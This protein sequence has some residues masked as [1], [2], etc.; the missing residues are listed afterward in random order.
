MVV[1]VGATMKAIVTGT[2][3]IRENSSTMTAVPVVAPSPTD[4][5][6]APESFS[7][8][9]YVVRVRAVLPLWCAI[10]RDALALH[11]LKYS[12]LLVYHLAVQPFRL[13]SG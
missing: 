11:Y 6:L 3:Q 8:G 9:T 5:K 2:W 4:P 7:L 13:F 1:I 12:T 10:C